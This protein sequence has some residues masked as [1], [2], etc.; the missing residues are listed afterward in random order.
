MPKM[1]VKITSDNE[2][3]DIFIVPYLLFKEVH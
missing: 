3:N 2:H 1:V